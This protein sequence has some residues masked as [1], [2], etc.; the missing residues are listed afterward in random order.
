MQW[1][2]AYARQI[3]HYLR[4]RWQRVVAGAGTHHADDNDAWPWWLPLLVWPS[5]ATLVLVSCA[6]AV[7]T[8]VW[9]WPMLSA[10]SHGVIAPT[11]GV[12]QQDI[13]L[14]VWNAWHFVNTW[15]TGDW[16]LT[17]AVFYPQQINL[18][19]Q[20]YGLTQLVLVAPIT[21]I[22]GPIAG[23][24]SIL[25]WGY[26]GGALG[27][28]LVVYA[29]TKRVP[30]AF[31][32]GWIFAITPAHQT[33]VAWSAAE[34]ASIQWVVLLHIS[35][36]W[37][38]RQPTWWR[39]GVVW[40]VLLINTLASRYFGLFGIVYA[41]V[42]VGYALWVRGMPAWR[43][44]VLM[45]ASIVCV[46]WVSAIAVLL[47]P[48]WVAY[49]YK[50]ATHIAIDRDDASFAN[51]DWYER[52]SNP[53]L[54]VSLLDLVMPTPDQRWW[55]WLFPNLRVDGTQMG[56]YLG[57]SVLLLVGWAGWREPA[58][59]PLLGV[60]GLLLLCAAGL[61]VR[62]VPDAQAPA[63]PGIFWLFDA[64][65]LFRNATRPGLFVL[66]AWIPIL[67]VIAYAG[68]R[69]QH[70]MF[71]LAACLV[72]WLDFAPWA[73]VISP[74]QATASATV[75]RDDA[76]NGSVLTLPFGKNDARPLLD[77]IC[78]GRPIAAGYLARVPPFVTSMRQI[79]VPARSA[80]D[81]IPV[82]PVD[83]LASLGVR[84]VVLKDTAAPY[85]RAALQDGGATRV[86][87]DTDAEVWQI[88]AATRPALVPGAGW[89]EPEQGVTAQGESTTWR[90]SSAQSEVLIISQQDGVVRM[91]LGVS[92]VKAARM[93][94][95]VNGAWSFALDVPA[96]PVFN[97]RVVV[98]PV[99]A[100]LNQIV[101]AMTPT[102]DNGR[103][104][105]AAFTRLALIGS[106]TIPHG[107]TLP[108]VPRYPQRWL[109]Q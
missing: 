76:T 38:L 104:I 28:F 44:Q 13:S 36:M 34:N 9:T 4:A 73:W 45:R 55:A 46:V 92:G 102:H 82:V 20:A 70:P 98:L 22:W 50:A 59:R 81:V 80:T 84:F 14:N 88:P 89:G 33:Y 68:S 72:V 39:S 52:Q 42:F 79:M 24:N 78:H 103:D 18:L 48:N 40:L 101:F 90:W 23:V 11:W 6:Y 8:V 61:Y 65:S 31:V 109:C 71:I 29:I 41:G 15:Q 30:L 17:Q 32:V 100:G 69:S 107:A 60:A 83:E 10:F 12:N 96:Q 105:G 58:V 3:V 99:Q 63:L 57:I 37:W 91:A 49:P 74:Q 47:I 1:M 62:L 106:S 108:A 25:A 21:A 53:R 35:V 56:G 86:W 85:V 87:Q 16:L 54:S 67:L 43:H 95:T 19:R 94:V 7:L 2:T 26:W 75:M 27:M 66:W 93:Q 51:D 5:R 77:Q 64:V 97:E